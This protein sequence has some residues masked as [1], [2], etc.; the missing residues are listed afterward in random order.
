MHFLKVLNN[1]KSA[2]ITTLEQAQNFK[3]S[4]KKNNI[5]RLS[6]EKTPK[7]LNNRTNKNTNEDMSEEERAKFEEEREA[8]KRSIE[9]DWKE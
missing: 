9:E 1:W 8:F 6:K 2:N 5:V 3:I 4:N 7:W